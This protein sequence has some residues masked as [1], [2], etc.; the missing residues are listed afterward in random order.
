MRAMIFMLLGSFLIAAAFCYQE[1]L[2][3][4][5]FQPAYQFLDEIKINTDILYIGGFLAIVIGIF[6]GLPA[7]T[8][9]FLFLLLM[10]GSGYYIMDRDISIT[11][12]NMTILK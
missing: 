8:S 2:F 1:Q 4:E 6:A 9:F 12:D 3:M 11:M 7:W 5:F 10:V